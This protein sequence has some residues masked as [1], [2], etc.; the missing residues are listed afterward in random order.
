MLYFE[1][2]GNILKALTNNR[3]KGIQ[4]IQDFSLQC[5]FSLLFSSIFQLYMTKLVCQSSFWI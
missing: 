4:S 1:G 2:V 3:Y 5:M